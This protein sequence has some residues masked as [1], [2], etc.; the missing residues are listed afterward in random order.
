MLISLSL[1]SRKKKKSKKN[2]DKDQE[3]T[4][5][6]LG[7]GVSASTSSEEQSSLDGAQ[8]SDT[9]NYYRNKTKAEIAF[10]KRKEELVS[11][12]TIQQKNLF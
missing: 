4:E 12:L 8:S 7:A 5:A 9:S 11:S 10:L 3:L 6:V 1:Q 2:K